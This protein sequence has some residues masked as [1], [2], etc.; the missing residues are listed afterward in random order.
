MPSLLIE[1]K[2]PTRQRQIF[3]AEFPLGVDFIAATDDGV[4]VIIV[5][6]QADDAE[7]RTKQRTIEVWANID[8]PP[9]EGRTFLGLL[10]NNFTVW[11][12]TEN[13]IPDNQV[14]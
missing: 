2:I 1:F 5:Y 6:Y 14:P 10:G 8:S 4:D 7:T 11:E 3:Q 13:T 12:N 9:D